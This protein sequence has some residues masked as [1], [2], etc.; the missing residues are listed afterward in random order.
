LAVGGNNE[1]PE[2][3]MALY[4]PAALERAMRIQE[5]IMKAMDKQISWL[6]A[7]EIIGISARSMRR[8]KQRYDD[9]GYDGLYDHRLGR[10]SP[11]R[12][13][14]ETVERVLALYRE[15]YFDFNVRHFHEKLVEDEG[16]T[17]SYTWV[18]KA[19]R[20]GGGVPA[21]DACARQ[22][23]YHRTGAYERETGLASALPGRSSSCSTAPCA[24]PKYGTSG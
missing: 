24:R 12:V 14:V 19:C 18:K 23:P 3:R 17:L 5:V 6:A 22:G 9:Y 10:P 13:P 15:K 2:V 16:I 1:C 7:A 4:P 20:A 21:A 11:K 8:W